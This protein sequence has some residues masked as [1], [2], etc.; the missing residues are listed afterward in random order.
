MEQKELSGALFK[1]DRKEHEK[2][3]DYRGDAKINGQEY[4][5]SAWV[6]EGKKGK[7]FSLAFTPKGSRPQPAAPPQVDV[8]DDIDG[9]LPF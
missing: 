8:V 3:P 6:K 9:D 4:W 7:F 1:N 2:Q 5:I